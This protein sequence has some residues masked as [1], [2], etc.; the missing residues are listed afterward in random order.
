MRYEYFSA[1]MPVEIGLLR[2]FSEICTAGGNSGYLHSST[3]RAYG[4]VNIPPPLKTYAHSEIKA[5][6]APFRSA[7]IGTIPFLVLAAVVMVYSVMLTLKHTFFLSSESP[8]KFQSQNSLLLI[9]IF[10]IFVG[11]QVYL[12]MTFTSLNKGTYVDG[13]WICAYSI[14]TGIVVFMLSSLV[15]N[16]NEA[17]ELHRRSEDES[18]RRYGDDVRHY[19]LVSVEPIQETGI[20]YS[21]SA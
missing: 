21:F 2:C 6:T 12:V 11:S 19:Q 13:I 1:S 15:D 9:S 8:L 14:L 4:S 16:L 10:S 20:S 7:S 17:A 18:I 3:S 5:F